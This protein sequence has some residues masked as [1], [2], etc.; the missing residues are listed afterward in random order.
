MYLLWLV[1]Y[2]FVCFLD[3]LADWDPGNLA[4][5]QESNKVLLKQHKQHKN[6]CD[7]KF[8]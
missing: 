7:S 5:N 4:K 3:L 2:V 8:Q 6:S 1:G